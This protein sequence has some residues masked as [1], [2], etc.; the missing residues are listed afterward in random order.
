M[1]T[2]FG[3]CLISSLGQFTI[4]TLYA[5]NDV[6]AFDIGPDFKVIGIENK[7]KKWAAAFA[8]FRGELNYEVRD[9]TVSIGGEVAFSHSC[10]RLVA[11]RSDGTKGGIWVRV[12]AC[13]RKIGDHWLIAH[14]H[15]SVPVDTANSKALLNLEPGAKIH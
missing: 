14:D 5:P 11:T 6:F 13:F 4:K 8:A 9:L 2:L 3:R 7:M 10:N 1:K 15:I 12:T